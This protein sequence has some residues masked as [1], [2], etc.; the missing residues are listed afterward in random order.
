MS[1]D[2][3]NSAMYLPEHKAGERK[4]GL[5]CSKPYQ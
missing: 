4:K 1:D 3:E 2:G 5:H